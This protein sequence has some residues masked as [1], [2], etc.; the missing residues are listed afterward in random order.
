MLTLIAVS[1]QQA[2]QQ[3][4]VMRCPLHLYRSWSVDVRQLIH[5]ICRDH[6]S[7][8]RR[9]ARHQRLGPELQE[10]GPALH[11]ATC[12]VAPLQTLPM[13]R[14]NW[15]RSQVHVFEPAARQ[16]CVIGTSY[17]VST[18]QSRKQKT[19]GR[20]RYCY[21]QGDVLTGTAMHDKRARR[22][23]GGIAAGLHPASKALYL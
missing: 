1:G 7:G 9:A 3:Y 21:A 11:P 23:E 20:N 19:A 17:L 8:T 5:T 16:A 12:A 22:I 4:R 15:R 18:T 2:Q 14:L 6:L 10:T 13:T